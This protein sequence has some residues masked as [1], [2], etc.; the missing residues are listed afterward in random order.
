[1]NA[2]LLNQWPDGASTATGARPRRLSLGHT[3]PGGAHKLALGDAL[4]HFAAAEVSRPFDENAGA[5]A[6]KGGKKGGPGDKKADK[7]DAKRPGSKGGKKRRRGAPDAGSRRSPR[8]PSTPPPRRRSSSRRP[9]T[10]CMPHRTLALVFDLLKPG[11]S[12]SII[13]GLYAIRQ[14]SVELT[15]RH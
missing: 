3:H 12:W 4:A 2:V 15:T 13:S 1:M 8:V 11:G 14:V 9:S 10:A 5:K 7:K 6:A